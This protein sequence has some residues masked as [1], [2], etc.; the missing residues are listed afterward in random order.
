MLVTPFVI[1]LVMLI[2]M[3]AL[4]TVG[5]AFTSFNGFSP[6]RFAGLDT[7]R[8]VLSDPELHQS[9]G[10]S[11]IFLAIALPL[12][13]LGAL[14]LALLANGRG[15]LAATT[16]VAVYAPAVIP[17]PAVALI[18][19]WIVNP[20]YG[21]VGSLVR[22]FGV[23]PGPVLIDPWGAR[24]TIAALS[25]FALGE[26]F[27]VTLAARREVSEN[28]YD[29]ARVEGAR[30]W[31]Q[32]RRIT[33]PFLAPT[34]ALLLA[35]DLLTSMQSAL[36][37]TLLLT[38]GGPLGATKTLPALVYERGFA[39]S[40]LG[41]GAALAVLLFVAGLILLSAVLLIRW[42]LKRREA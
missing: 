19:L 4:V 31:A 17:D 42:W 24:L 39:E 7:F 3:P 29:A 33:L 13:V 22:L 41:E 18:W 11:A 8:R 38:R 12:R 37:P 14:G 25:A 2:V 36:V 26:G 34:L 15:R 5:F 32:F 1:G 35:R 40:Q 23:T 6:A 16:R 20:F 30:A 27:L 21:P 28:L 9:L 10:A